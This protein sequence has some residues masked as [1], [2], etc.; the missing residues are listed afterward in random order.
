MAPIAGVNAEPTIAISLNGDDPTAPAENREPTDRRT[1]EQVVAQHVCLDPGYQGRPLTVGDAVGAGVARPVRYG[2]GLRDHVRRI[3]GRRV[4]GTK[5]GQL[6]GDEPDHRHRPEIAL[7]RHTLAAYPPDL[8]IEVPGMYVPSLEFHQAN[9][10]IEIGR[11][12][13]AAAPTP[14][15]RRVLA[16]R[17]SGRLPVGPAHGR[18][19]AD[20]GRQSGSSGLGPNAARAGA[21]REHRLRDSGERH[22]SGGGAL[23]GLGASSAAGT[24]FATA[25][26]QSSTTPMLTVLPTP[27]MAPV[28]DRHRRQAPGTAQLAATASTSSTPLSRVNTT[29]SPVATSHGRDHGDPGPAS[30]VGSRL[31]MTSRRTASGTVS[32]PVPIDP[33]CCSFCFLVASG[34]SS[35]DSGTARPPGPS[36]CRVAALPSRPHLTLRQPVQRHAATDLSRDR[37]PRRG[38]QQHVRT[39]PGRR[40][41]RILVGDAS[42]RRFS[43]R[44]RPVPAGQDQARLTNRGVRRRRE[45]PAGRR[46]R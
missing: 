36:S 3:R 26:P 19:S 6:R 34:S 21:I 32:A 46:P 28:V 39:R 38:P 4:P 14:S 20:G 18:P 2:R 13:G 9:E 15:G 31:A 23:H 37:R 33:M 35:A 41:R 11:E 8:F 1:L 16:P 22:R 12:L 30:P 44:S 25:G 29:S 5:A 27:S 45:H 10:V 40:Q 43:W 42:G 17:R 24:S 7:A